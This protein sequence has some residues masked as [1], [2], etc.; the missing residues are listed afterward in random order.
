MEKNNLPDIHLIDYEY[1]Q[2]MKNS[3][4]EKIIPLTNG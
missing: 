1:P 4:K 3:P 2:Y